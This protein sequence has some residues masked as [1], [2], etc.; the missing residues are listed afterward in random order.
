MVLIGGVKYACERCIRGHRVT[1]CNHTDQPLMMIKP[2][3]RPSSQCKHCKDM[4]KNKNSHSTGSCTCSKVKKSISHTSVNT[5]NSTKSCGCEL[6][7]PCV[8]HTK[9]KPTTSSISKK[10]RSSSIVDFN[11]PTPSSHNESTPSNINSIP[12]STST[13]T[14]N[15]ELNSKASTPIQAKITQIG[16]DPIVKSRP[17]SQTTRKRVGEVSVPINEYI[18]KNL[19]GIGNVSD[20]IPEGFFQ[21]VPLPFEPGHGLLDLFNDSIKSIMSP[22]SSSSV[23]TNNSFFT[24]TA[25]SSSSSTTAAPAPPTNYSNQYRSHNSSSNN[26]FYPARTSSL[27]SINLISNRN[28]DNKI[29]NDN[30]L[31]NNNTNSNVANNTIDNSNGNNKSVI[32]SPDSL[33][34]YHY[35][36]MINSKSK[37]LFQSFDSSIFDNNSETS[38]NANKVN[39]YNNTKNYSNSLHNNIDDATSIHSVEV[40]SLTP[41]F[42]DLTNPQ[43]Q[44]YFDLKTSNSSNNNIHKDNVNTVST[45]DNINDLD[46]SSLTNGNNVNVNNINNNNNNIKRSK[47]I[48]ENTYNNEDQTKSLFDNISIRM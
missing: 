40:L 41:S 21:D 6:N 12:N 46:L 23:P 29:N 11:I 10:S 36:N 5:L 3:G 1:T 48:L 2:K 32:E 9:R 4:R 13:S 22:T 31:F 37:P 26:Q 24:N 42:M 18:P 20:K 17:I 28:S 39:S 25:S 45:Q 15:S 27:A 7:K 34:D 14:L 33:L 35:S 47:S 19:N 30:D 43:D 44:S 16:L 38:N 8:C